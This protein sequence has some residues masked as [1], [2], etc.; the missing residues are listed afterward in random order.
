MTHDTTT[1]DIHDT[2]KDTADMAGTVAHPYSWI[3][4]C[5]DCG[6]DTRP[7]EPGSKGIE[8][9]CEW[10]SVW[11]YLWQEAGMQ[12]ESETLWSSGFLCVGCLEKRLG[13]ELTADGAG[14]RGGDRGRIDGDR[15][16]VRRPGRR[17]RL[18]VAG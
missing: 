8:G 6:M 5:L 10:Y 7:G 16:A 15:C 3:D 18:L 11:D 13:R 14:E 9:Q 4:I 1:H 17:G 12:S 2:T